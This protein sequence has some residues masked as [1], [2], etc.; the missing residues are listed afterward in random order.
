MK[1]LTCCVNSTGEVIQDMVDRPREITYRTLLKYVSIEHLLETFPCYVK[2]KSMGL[3]INTDYGVSFCKSTYK[4][5][6]CVY[7][8]HSGIEYIFT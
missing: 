8:T 6:K 5:R 3:T 4:G 7:V 1:Y 2:Y